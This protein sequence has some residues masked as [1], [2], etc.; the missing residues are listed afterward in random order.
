LAFVLCRF[1]R[2]PLPADCT[3]S[4]ASSGD[5]AGVQSV[6][7]SLPAEFINLFIQNPISA[8]KRRGFYEYSSADDFTS[9][10]SHDTRR[11]GTL[12]E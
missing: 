7:L 10:T 9:L 6:G 3:F 1:E 4:T 12:L 11:S 2:R 8:M 5:S